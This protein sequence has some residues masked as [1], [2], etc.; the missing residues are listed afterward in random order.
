MTNKKNE[1]SY[2]GP[3]E[4]LGE[5]NFGIF[6]ISVYLLAEVG[7]LQDILGFVKPMKITFM[8]AAGSALYAAYLVVSGRFTLA[9]ADT[10]KKFM[11][12]TVF[13]VLYAVAATENPD[14]VEMYYKVY[15]QY[16]SFYIIMVSCVR[17]LFQFIFVVDVWLLSVTHTSFHAIAQGGLLY[18]SH[19]WSDENQLALVTAYAVPCALM[20]FMNYKN[21]LIRK[22]FY[23]T[24]V[25]F[26]TAAVVLSVSRGGALTL[27]FAGVSCLMLFKNKVRN[28]LMLALAVVCVLNFAPEEFFDEMETLEQGTQEHTADTRIYF[29][30]MALK[31][32]YDNPVF[33]VGPG[34]Y[35]YNQIHYDTRRRLY[36]SHGYHKMVAHSTPM[37]WL[38][39]YG[40][41]GTLMLL[42][43][44]KSLMG[45]WR[46]V[47]L[48]LNAPEFSA[49]KRF[50]LLKGLNHAFLISLLS[51]WV[52]AS[53]ISVDIYPIFWV[54]VPF[55]VVLRRI[56]TEHGD[57]WVSR[58]GGPG[59]GGENFRRPGE[60]G[61]TPPSTFSA[62]RGGP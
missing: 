20:M 7:S 12:V 45:N 53:F 48:R 34:N 2:P 26:Y 58:G 1:F 8:Y 23:L 41:V 9:G 6:L 27:F 24:S 36:K 17:T 31:M 54:I 4:N 35:A 33:G 38:A 11:V 56:L 22:S 15:I 37:Q 62:G 46:A 55:S 59:P 39:E 28:F 3:F 25:I 32:Y 43:L 40:T 50:D 42:V 21:S 29:W 51:F 47:R 57:S 19:W 49:D 44:I 61:K 60:A 52:G 30:G 13:S 10:N 18:G 14:A 5:V 16:A